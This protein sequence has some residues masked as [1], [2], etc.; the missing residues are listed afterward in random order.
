MLVRVIILCFVVTA[1]ADRSA[2][3][4][5]WTSTYKEVYSSGQMINNGHKKEVVF[6]SVDTIP[7]TQL[8]FSWNAVRPAR[9][10]FSF[11]IQ[12][13]DAKTKKWYDWHK[14]VEWGNGIQR[15]FQ[16]KN[17]GS[18]FC[19]ARLELRNHK[20]ADAFRIKVL[21]QEP[22]DLSL[23]K[24]LIA[25]VSHSGEF[26][27]EKYADRGR[28]LETFVLKGIPLASQFLVD[29]P[30]AD[31]LCSPTSTSMMVGALKGRKIDP[32]QFANYVYDDGLNQFG[33]WTF[34]TAHAYEHC[35][36]K[37]LFY[38]TRLNSFTELYDILRKKIPVVVSVR[39]PLKD[40][41]RPYLG[42]HL[43]LVVGWD[44][45]EQKVLCHDPA[46]ETEEE[47][48]MAYD[49]HE[50]VTA[51]ERSRRMTYKPHLLVDLS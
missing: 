15:S 36:E 8:I 27:S 16:S 20:N 21:T 35:D 50:F 6:T 3:D 44:E 32:L 29:H 10:F 28:G 38:A 26:I 39:G 41:P 31:S 4:N 47:V 34:N 9:G 42:G 48:F 19:Y 5:M 11:Y 37:V 2:E 12:V 14:M 25:S 30:R 46:F 22:Q 45:Q 51:W 13:R 18:E 43:L 7:F 17:E 40:A 33:N 24:A 49:I 1:R 23:V